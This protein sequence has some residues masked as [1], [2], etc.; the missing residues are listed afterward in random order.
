[1]ALRGTV[2]IVADL[3]KSSTCSVSDL[4]H[5]ISYAVGGPEGT[6]ECEDCMRQPALHRLVGS[7]EADGAAYGASAE[8]D[9]IRK[10]FPGDVC[11]VDAEILD[12][13]DD[14]INDL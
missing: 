11:S 6:P 1:M 4:A 14:H 5:P 12:A 3:F 9:P 8:A 2:M 10:L 7:N 13:L